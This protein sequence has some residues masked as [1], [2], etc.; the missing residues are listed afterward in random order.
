MP[1]QHTGRAPRIPRVCIHCGA[2]F[3]ADPHEV[4]RRGG[5]GKF[6]SRPCNYAYREPLEDRFWRQVQ[7]GETCWLWT[8]KP[9]RKGYG[10]LS[11]SGERDG[12]LS[13]HRYSWLLHN[14]P[15]PDETPCVLHNC[16]SGDNPSCVNPSHLWL[17]TV[18]DNN[19]DMRRKGREGSGE[20][21]GSRTHPET[22]RRGEAHAASKATEAMVREIRAR[23]A[24]GETHAA[25]AVSVGLSRR[26]VSGI[27]QRKFW[28]HVT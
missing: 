5:G 3:L 18:A 21:H 12:Y 19:A 15:I 10:V 28:R 14:G 2:S 9:D 4:K 27:A 1:N 16:P 22:I 23:C 7:K 26:H 6:C 25:V 24:A 20:R 17:G 13:A 11:T 8:G